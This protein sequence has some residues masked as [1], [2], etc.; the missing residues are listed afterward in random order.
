MITKQL[1][2]NRL[3]LKSANRT[4]YFS[5]AV[6]FALLL[7]LFSSAWAQQSENST[8]QTETDDT[9]STL[10]KFTKLRATRQN[11]IKEIERQLR[12]SPSDSE[13]KELER[14]LAELLKELNTIKENF[15]EIAAGIS[16]SAISAKEDKS[17]NLQAEM[18]SL[19][20]PVVR[21]MKHMTSEVRKKS[22]IREEIT[23]YQTRIPKARVAIENV[24]AL[25][26]L[27]KNKSLKEYLQDILNDWK[28]HLANMESQLQALELQLSRI[29]SAE[30]SFS[31][32]SH[33]YLK[34]FFQK[35]GLYLTQALVVVAVILLLSRFSHKLIMRLVP[36][37]RVEHRSFRIRLLD[38]VHR[39][40]TVALTIAGPMVVFYVAEDWVL[41]SLG[42]LLLLGAAWTLRTAIPRYWQQIRIYLNIGSVREGERILYEGLPWRVKKIDIFTQLE[43]PDAGISQ[44]IA[45]EQLV[46]L[47]SRPMRNDEPWF[48]CRKDD[49]VILSD[50]VRGKVVGISHEL[51]ELVERGGAHKTYLTQD[52]LG[53][54]PR[55]LSID[56][57]LKEVIGVSYDLQ[58][59]STTT[60]L[61]TLK[62]HLLKR[63]E[64]EGYLPDLIQLNVEFHSANT[65]SLD[66]MVLADFKGVQAPLYNRLR[67]A[68]QRWCVDA[69]T[70]NNWEIPFT[71]LT[72]H[73]RN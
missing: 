5:A 44:R 60:M 22:D 35:R 67:R 11:Q 6:V 63:I 68:I 69:C 31:E 43:N 13:K 66:L 15:V 29:E 72:L 32:A 51:V 17:F 46:D 48:P 41:F 38:L 28:R 25:I 70:E 18:L 49:W 33:T 54:S 73:N 19:M 57:R 50:G 24:S 4:V 37:Y 52:F 30:T 14:D 8:E 65:S 23:F 53:Q 7:S 64:A 16:F 71:Q 12:S 20:E 27:A 42:V 3:P 56:F 9:L 58:S 61:Q 21:E 47:K 62:A 34:T 2:Y 26:E 59:I 1:L 36:G 39:M 55:N 10:L 40:I 45:I